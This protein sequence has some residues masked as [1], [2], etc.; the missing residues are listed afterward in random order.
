[1]V[2]MKAKILLIF[3]NCEKYS[4]SPFYLKL[5][6]QLSHNVIKQVILLAPPKGRH[7]TTNF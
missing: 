7:V 1:M 3:F 4:T 2:F 5:F 6:F